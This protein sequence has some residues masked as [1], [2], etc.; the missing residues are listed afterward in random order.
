MMTGVCLVILVAAPGCRKG[1]AINAPDMNAPVRLGEVMRE[2]VEE[3]VV[4]NGTLKASEQAVLVAENEGRLVMGLNAKGERLTEGDV[5]EVG[6]IVAI[7]E[8]PSL[9][10]STALDARKEEA[11][12]AKLEL[13]RLESKLGAGL[14]ADNVIEPARA[15]ATSRKY[16]YEAA[17]AQ[18]EKLKVVS[19]ISGR[20]VKLTEIVDGDRVDP[21]TEIATVMSYRTIRADV[22]IPNQDF[23]LIETNQVVRVRNFAIKNEV[24]DGTV[25][26]IY[27]VADAQTGAF[28]AEI[29]VSN[30]DEK[31]RPGMFT[32][33][34]IVVSR[35]EDAVVVPLEL[36][37]TRNNALVVFVVEDQKAVAHEVEVGIETREIAEIL[38]GIEPDDAL[39]VEGFETLRDGTPVSVLR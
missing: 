36:V 8:N 10:A 12:N 16:A 15:T 9:V 11:D 27:P 21:G 24:F 30:E 38:G 1:E 25:T 35:H 18:L 28:S 26:M 5:V 34:E 20:I 3:I 29:A 31:L 17:V 33:V 7:L 4:T 13:K 22:N 39:I 32:Q 23:P 19:P 14:F 6:Q 2:A 37:L